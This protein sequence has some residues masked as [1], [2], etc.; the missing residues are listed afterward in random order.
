LEAVHH[1]IVAIFPPKA[2]YV[3]NR[4]LLVVTAQSSRQ[5]HIACSLQGLAITKEG[6]LPLLAGDRSLDW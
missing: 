5:R 6:K 1:P 3:S 2:L 4:P